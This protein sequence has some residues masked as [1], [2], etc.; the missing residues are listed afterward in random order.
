MHQLIDKKNKITIYLM[1]LLILSS[2][3]YKIQKDN[4]NYL[5]ALVKINVSGLPNNKNL[6]IE[7]RIKKLSFRNILFINKESIHDIL[8]Q[9]NL[10]ESY[11]IK[12]I[13]PTNIN[14]KIKQTDF[15]AKIKGDRNFLVGSNGKLI[16][17]EYTDKRLPHLFG[18][19]NSQKFLEFKKILDSSEF[20]FNDLQ[21][22][23]FFPSMRWDVKTKNNTLIKLPEKNILQTLKI[24]YKII[25]DEKLK[26]NQIIDLR[27]SKQVI[28]QK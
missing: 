15:V 12:K 7:Q 2:T 25:N 24:A 23:F 19:F 17:D 11:N 8:S 28:I 9:Y 16:S 26:D 27:I 21:A 20:I 3:N 10:V 22:I 6:L 13:Y 18:K 14:I 1:L 5:D 4:K